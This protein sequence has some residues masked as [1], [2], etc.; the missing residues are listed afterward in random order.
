MLKRGEYQWH[1]FNFFRR[2]HYLLSIWGLGVCI[3]FWGTFLAAL[4]MGESLNS[5]GSL[6]WRVTAR[7]PSPLY[8][9]PT[10]ISLSRLT[11]VYMY[12]VDDI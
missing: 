11:N 1:Q 10:L 8:S 9:F 5:V 2:S 3:V 12:F 7:V 4:V 6:L